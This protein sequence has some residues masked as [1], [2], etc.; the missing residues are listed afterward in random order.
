MKEYKQIGLKLTPQRLAILEYLKDNREH[1]SA[2]DIYAA[3]SKKFPTMSFATVYNTLKALKDKE[4]VLEL[5]IDGGKKRYDPDTVHH[6]HLICTE[7]RKIVDI[8]VEFDLYVPE[9]VQNGFEIAGNHVDFYGI[10]PECRE[11]GA[12]QRQTVSRKIRKA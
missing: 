1:P 8:F 5:A 3:V 10:C 6:H 7:C 12:I 9:A 2:A 4:H 11:K